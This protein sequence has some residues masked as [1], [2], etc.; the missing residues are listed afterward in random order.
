MRVGRLITGLIVL[1]LSAAT[2]DL[3]WRYQK[4]YPEGLLQ[5]HPTNRGVAFWGDNL[6]MATN[7]SRPDA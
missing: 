1:A 2:G 5:L 4:K 3:Y 7:D 6:Y